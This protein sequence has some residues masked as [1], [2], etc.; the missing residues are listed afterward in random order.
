M[1]CRYDVK[2]VLRGGTSQETAYV[3]DAAGGRYTAGGGSAGER[4]MPSKTSST[5]LRPCGP[6]PW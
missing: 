6:M 2:A 4:R 5:S 3:C 1:R